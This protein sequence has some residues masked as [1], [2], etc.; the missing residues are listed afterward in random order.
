M[1]KDLTATHWTGT[2]TKL[3]KLVNHEVKLEGDV[4]IVTGVLS[5]VPDDDTLKLLKP[6]DTATLSMVFGYKPDSVDTREIRAPTIT[7]R[8]N[9]R[10]CKLRVYQIGH[11]RDVLAWNAE[12]LTTAIKRAP[13]TYVI[14]A[15]IFKQHFTES[16]WKHLIKNIQQ[17]GFPELFKQAGLDDVILDHFVTSWTGSGDNRGVRIHIRI[18]TAAKERVLAA[19]G[20]YGLLTKDFDAAFIAG[21][22]KWLKPNA[23]E[24]GPDFIAR[25]SKEAGNTSKKGLAYS[26]TGSI[27]MRVDP[28]AIPSMWRVSGLHKFVTKTEL[29]NILTNHGW[30][31]VESLSKRTHKSQATW[32]IRGRSKASATECQRYEVVEEETG[33]SYF[34]EVVPFRPAPKAKSSS[35]TTPLKERPQTFERKATFQ[36]PVDSARAPTATE[37]A[38]RPE[39]AGKVARTES[40]HRPS[41]EAVD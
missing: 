36:E 18:P 15:Q 23:D 34:V 28:G 38:K 25:A 17:Q 13:D 7:S 32:I 26:S 19:S 4:H 3:D 35:G 14:M 29:Q 6:S 11:R 12:K 10:I 9:T 33:D 31:D 40:R 8:G 21:S 5:K 39:P 22:V 37:R 30:E 16:K 24:S 41:T 20:T 2:L 27:G 1:P